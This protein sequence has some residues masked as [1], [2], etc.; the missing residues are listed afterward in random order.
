MARQETAYDLGFSRQG[1]IDRIKNDYIIRHRRTG[2]HI[3]FGEAMRERKAQMKMAA[4][5]LDSL[6][7]GG[8]IGWVMLKPRR[9][10]WSTFFA[11][12][13]LEL[14]GQVGW[15]VGIMG[16]EEE[17]T[18][19]IFD[20]GR[21]AYER[22]RAS[23]KPELRF[24]R[25]NKLV[26][27]T[28]HRDDRSD[29]DDPGD[30]NSFS[31]R[32]AGGR[33]PFSGAT[34]RY[35]LLDELAKWP[36]ES[37]DQWKIVNSVLNSM[38]QDGPTIRLFVSTA[39]GSSGAF[40]ETFVEAKKYEHKPGFYMYRP[41]FMA[42]F[43]DEGSRREVPDEILKAWDEHPKD[44]LEREE[45]LVKEF[46]LTKEQLFF[47]RQKIQ[48]LG[49]VDRFRQEYPGTWQEAFLASGRTVFEAETIEFQRQNLKPP[50][51]SGE[52][53]LQ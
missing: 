26:F 33:H 20:I 41:H 34:L 17:S 29:D 8:P 16:H 36:G 2:K 46:S 22:M 9:C 32:T 47:R 5:I 28:H 15:D 23:A 4:Q 18:N 19:T 13:G 44:D 31:C 10:G 50:V 37:G 51:L 6:N 43:E 12:L 14:A 1:F 38:P 7:D 3:K 35:A 49:G 40:Y 27:G 42:W 25:V 45:Q 24:S 11:I 53:R 30:M 39:Y 48:E 52:V 21:I